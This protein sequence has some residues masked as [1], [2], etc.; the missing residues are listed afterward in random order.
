MVNERFYH[1]QNSD[2]APKRLKVSMLLTLAV[3]CWFT[4]FQYFSTRLLWKWD[5]APWPAG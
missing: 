3:L 5:L 4:L 2:S 1:M